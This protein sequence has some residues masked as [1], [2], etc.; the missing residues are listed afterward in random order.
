MVRQTSGN[1]S[2]APAPASAETVTGLAAA[3]SAGATLQEPTAR[4]IIAAIHTDTH[5]EEQCRFIA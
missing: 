4:P 1:A 2:Y 3:V 5:L